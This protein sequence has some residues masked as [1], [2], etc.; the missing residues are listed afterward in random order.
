MVELL[1]LNF[2]SVSTNL[3]DHNWCLNQFSFQV[4]CS[5]TIW[6]I[7]SPA[8]PCLLSFWF[9]WRHYSLPLDL[10]SQR[11]RL[12]KRWTSLWSQL[13]QA[14]TRPRKPVEL[15]TQEKTRGVVYG[16]KVHWPQLG[17]RESNKSVLKDLQIMGIVFIK[18]FLRKLAQVSILLRV[19]RLRV[20]KIS[21]L[22]F[23]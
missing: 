14:R 2:T 9:Q 16:N 17:W 4:V 12:K 8:I 1:P 3:S 19:Q 5:W 23:F 18:F 21:S 22:L 7:R 6:S 13:C 20:S 15:S 11:F 10:P